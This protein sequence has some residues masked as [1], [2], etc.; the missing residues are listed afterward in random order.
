MTAQSSAQTIVVVDDDHGVRQFIASVLRGRGYQVLEAAGGAAALDAVRQHPGPVHLLLT[1]V[2]MPDL[3]G[4]SL[5]QSLSRLRPEAKVLFISGYP[6]DSP[7]ADSSL[8]RK[9]FSVPDLLNKVA[10]L[11]C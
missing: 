6:A 9:P 10:Q 1:D 8:L 2:L 5:W 11:I 7:L 4:P 3:D